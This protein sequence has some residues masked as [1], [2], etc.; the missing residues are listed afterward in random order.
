MYKVLYTEW[1]KGVNEIIKVQTEAQ[2]IR[3]S[4]HTLCD[5]FVNILYGFIYW[6]IILILLRKAV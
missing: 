3:I 1:L 4:N 5:R 6:F 2:V